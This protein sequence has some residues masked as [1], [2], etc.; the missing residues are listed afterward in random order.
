MTIW[1][2]IYCGYLNFEHQRFCGQHEGCG[3]GAPKPQ[4][5]SQD[6]YLV[7]YD[8]GSE[9]YSDHPRLEEIKQSDAFLALRQRGGYGQ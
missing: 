7:G 9:V 1:Q 5:L 2:C 4:D 8:M 3:C 6:V